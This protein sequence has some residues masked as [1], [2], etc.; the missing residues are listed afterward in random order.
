MR[1]GSD[2]A[3]AG[4]DAARALASGSS[5]SIANLASAREASYT[6]PLM[7]MSRQRCS[8]T[9]VGTSSNAT[10]RRSSSAR[11]M[12]SNARGQSSFRGPRGEVEGARGGEA[13]RGVIRGDGDG[14]NG[15]DSGPNPAP[16]GGRAASRRARTRERAR[17]RRRRREERRRERVRRPRRDGARKRRDRPCARSLLLDASKRFDGF[18]IFF[19]REALIRTTNSSSSR[20]RVIARLLG[21]S[22]SGRIGRVG[23]LSPAAV[24]LT[25]SDAGGETSAARSERPHL[26]SRTSAAGSRHGEEF[27][28]RMG[29]PAQ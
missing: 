22:A 26:R 1:S 29:E 4:V 7:P 2:E 15:C 23:R 10:E 8:R 16:R 27:A 3:R 20:S 5:R 11:S 18:L 24:D 12:S 17:A 14:K 28:V 9:T 19:E 25:Y 6:A 13:S 21:F